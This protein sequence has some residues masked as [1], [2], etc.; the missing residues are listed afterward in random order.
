MILF[1]HSWCSKALEE[2]VVE[3]TLPLM[4]SLLP[5]GN[6]QMLVSLVLM[7]FL[8]R[9]VIGM[10]GNSMILNSSVVTVG[11]QPV[12]TCNIY[13]SQVD[14]FCKVFTLTVKNML[15]VIQNSAFC[16]SI[17]KYIPQ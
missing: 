3:A 10:A 6:A 15:S 2:L 14:L 12:R 11:C 9:E 4:M 5:L 1:S 7:Q 17:V 8:H 13:E 16:N